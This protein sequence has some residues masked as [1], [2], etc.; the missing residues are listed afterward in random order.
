M[1]ELCESPYLLTEG[2]SVQRSGNM[3]R[4]AKAVGSVAIVLFVFSGLHGGDHSSTAARS[5]GRV[6]LAVV[7]ALHERLCYESGRLGVCALYQGA[8]AYRLVG[9]VT[10]TFYPGRWDIYPDEKVFRDDSFKPYLAKQSDVLFSLQVAQGPTKGSVELTVDGEKVSILVIGPGKTWRFPREPKTSVRDFLT[11]CSDSA[12]EEKRREESKLVREE[13][14]K[15][16]R[17]TNKREGGR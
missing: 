1:R 16:G 15:L 5:S 12:W 9:G 11:T 14:E 4:L 10:P 6:S 7:E 13:M 17:G 3:R 2:S 8:L